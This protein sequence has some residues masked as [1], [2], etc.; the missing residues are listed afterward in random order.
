M[1][2]NIDRVFNVGNERELV[3]SDGVAFGTDENKISVASE[4]L[5]SNQLLGAILKEL[6]IIRTHQEK[7]SNEVFRETDINEKE[8]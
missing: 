4:D 8:I 1:V 6:R 3:D 2:S 7:A 5:D